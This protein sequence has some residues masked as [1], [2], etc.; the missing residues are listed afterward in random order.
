MVK[1]ILAQALKPRI[2]FAGLCVLIFA[3]FVAA[4]LLIGKLDTIHV[5][6]SAAAVLVVLM[7][8]RRETGV[9]PYVMAIAHI[10]QLIVFTA[11]FSGH[12]W[13]IDTH[14]LYFVALAGVA[15]LGSIGALLTAAAT[16]AVHHLCFA[17]LLPELVFPGADLAGNLGRVAFHGA[18]VVAETLVLAL[19]MTALRRSESAL[20]D[21]QR[22]LAEESRKAENASQAAQDAARASGIVAEI[23]REKLTALAERRL[24]HRIDVEVPA[25]FVDMGKSFDTAMEQLDGAMQGA[26]RLA[27]DFD[28]EAQTLE[29]MTDMLSRR[30]EEQAHELSA[31]ADRIQEITSSLGRTARN[32]MSAVESSGDAQRQAKLSEEVTQRAV[33]AMGRIEKSSEAVAKIMDLID[34]IAF[35]TNL[36]S[37]NAGVEAARAG[38]AGKG[39]AVVAAEVQGLSQ[40]TAEAANKVKDLIL[41]SEREVADGARLVEETGEGLKKIIASVDSVSTMITGNHS[42][43]QVRMQDMNAVTESIAGLDCKTQETAAQ[44]EEMAALGI[45]LRDQSRR[46][47]ETMDQFMVSE[48]GGPL[49]R[50]PNRTAAERDVA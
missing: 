19:S 45:R 6:A 8:V 48:E 50:E 32:A 28:V 1:G 18:V 23:L 4:C 26:R 34:D 27:A 42:D 49:A 12:P 21:E 14:M 33:D 20:R 25:A 35:Q 15:V 16:I 30:N 13:Q 2:L 31:T 29:E 44:S 11:K 37:L 41:N 36:L 3:V 10:A 9:A 46:L 39:F 40:R 7:M 38:A 5:T 43:L 47:F 24:D 22:R 17:I